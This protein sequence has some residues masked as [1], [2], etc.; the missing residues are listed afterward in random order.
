MI[1]LK[2]ALDRTE[3]KQQYFD[4]KSTA[5]LTNLFGHDFC[6]HFNDDTLHHCIIYI[7]DTKPLVLCHMYGDYLTDEAVNN[8]PDL[9]DVL[10]QLP[11][12]NYA[13]LLFTLS[14]YAL[15]DKIDVTTLLRESKKFERYAE[16]DDLLLPTYGYVVYKHQ[17][18][19]LIARISNDNS[20]YPE[21][22]RM[23][24]NKKSH[25]TIDFLNTLMLT[26]TLNLTAFL[27]ERTIE[28]NHFVWSPNFRGAQLLYNYLLHKIRMP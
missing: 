21:Q 6:V 8:I 7:N 4:N 1:T 17:L 5:E 10:H 22:L 9:N 3:I 2:D 26:D 13:S 27:R 19:Q 20:L 15:Y 11:E 14:I 12:L 28:E 25:K 23:G 16:Y 18:E 24:W